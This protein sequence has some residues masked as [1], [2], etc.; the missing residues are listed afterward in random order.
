MAAFTYR[1]K[2]SQWLT[3]KTTE[4]HCSCGICCAFCDFS[5]RTPWF[6]ASHFFFTVIFKHAQL[7]CVN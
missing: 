2:H 4:V 1:L 6:I 3:K 7:S 5:Q